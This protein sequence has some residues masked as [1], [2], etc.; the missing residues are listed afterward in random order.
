MGRSILFTSE[1]VTEGHPDGQRVAGGG[2]V[3]A[4]DA[5]ERRDPGFAPGVEAGL[6]SGQADFRQVPGATNAAGDAAHRRIDQ[7]GDAGRP[8]LRRGAEWRRKP[9]DIAMHL[10]DQR[11]DSRHRIETEAPQRMQ[12]CQ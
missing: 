6:R 2:E 8:A 12:V 11:G 9:R 4:P 7:A 5:V 3:L 1:S 10:L